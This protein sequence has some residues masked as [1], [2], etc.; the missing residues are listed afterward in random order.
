MIPPEQAFCRRCR[1]ALNTHTSSFGLTYTHA[2]EARGSTVDHRPDPVAVTE[3]NDPLIE[4]DFCS[5][6]GAAWSYRCADQRT[7]TRTVTARIVGSND[8]RDQ[9]HAART[10]RVETGDGLTQAWGE[11]W[12]ACPECAELIEARD[13]L[14]LISRVVEV[15]PAKL[16]RGKRLVQVRGQLHGTYS[17]VFDTLAPGRG[18][19]EPGHPLGVWPEPPASTA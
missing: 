15:L 11:R 6:P 16:T 1:R 3:L 4:C 14:G 10:R 9:H 5:A 13:L 8:Y 17:T 18:R 7:T 12:S 19:I 2:I